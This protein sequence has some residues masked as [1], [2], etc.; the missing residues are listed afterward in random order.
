M[1]R[2]A[3]SIAIALTLALAAVVGAGCGA[4]AA[5]TGSPAAVSERFVDLYFVEVDQQK[6]LAIVDGPARLTL[7]DELAAVEGIRRDYPAAQA[8]PKVYWSRTWLRETGDA[9]RAIYDITIESEHSKDE[10]HVL[11]T[12]RRMA[13]AWKVTSFTIKQGK[14]PAPPSLR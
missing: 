12:L 2:S 13:G 11:I 3:R 9:A 14:A 6:A 10:R 8:R 4:D 5:P 7:E 1:R